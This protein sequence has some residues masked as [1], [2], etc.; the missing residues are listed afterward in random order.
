VAFIPVLD[1]RFRVLDFAKCPS[2][3]GSG[4]PF[5]AVFGTKDNNVQPD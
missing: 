4:Y 1:F 3:D 2:P 5:V